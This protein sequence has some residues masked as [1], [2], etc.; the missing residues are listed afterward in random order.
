MSVRNGA[1]FLASA[2]HSVLAQSFA[3]FEIILIDDA[4]TDATPEILRHFDDPRLAVHTS[5]TVLGLAAALN[6]AARHARG[7]YLARMDADDLCLPDRFAAQVHY[8]ETHPEVGIVGGAARYVDAGGLPLKRQPPPVP[9]APS[10]LRWTLY[11]RNCV[12]HPTVMMRRAVFERLG[13][14]DVSFAAAQDYDL[15]LRALDITDIANLPEVLLEYR[16]H[17]ESVT[18]RRGEVQAACALRAL[19]AALQRRLGGDLPADFARWMMQP[20]TIPSGQALRFDRHFMRLLACCAA[21]CDDAAARE[22]LCRDAAAFAARAALVLRRHA[23]I[24]AGVMALRAVLLDPG[25]FGPA[26]EQSLA[27][28]REKRSVHDGSA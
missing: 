20:R 2:L 3:D 15:W 13:G 12:R 4:S 14:Y 28:F 8:L 11:R 9:C 5:E 25:A 7:E 19:Q 6:L 17:A 22:A 24:S 26:L 23:W 21:R 10:L 16:E 1:P 27:A 18:S